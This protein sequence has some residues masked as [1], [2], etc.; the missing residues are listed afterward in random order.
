MTKMI[1]SELERRDSGLAAQY[2]REWID[3]M[4]DSEEFR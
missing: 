4:V 2:L 1:C 3:Q